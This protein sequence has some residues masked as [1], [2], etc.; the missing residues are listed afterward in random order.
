MYFPFLSIVEWKQFQK[1][2]L[3]LS[4]K[5]NLE[6]L[7][8]E[9]LTNNDV[10]PQISHN[11]RSVTEAESNSPEEDKQTKTNDKIEG[12]E[13]VNRLTINNI[14]NK[15][16]KEEQV[17][18]KTEDTIKMAY[19]AFTCHDSSAFATAVFDLKSKTSE[20]SGVNLKK[21]ETASSEM[22]R[23]QEN[24]ENSR[25]YIGDVS[26][27]R[28]KAQS[29]HN[30]PNSS[31]HRLG[32]SPEQKLILNE[33]KEDEKKN[34]SKSEA[35]SRK[36]SRDESK[37]E[38]KTGKSIFSIGKQMVHNLIRWSFDDFEMASSNNYLHNL[39]KRLTE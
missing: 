23:L 18:Q 7:R 12:L 20:R 28:Q 25:M 14:K 13:K 11:T 10:H 8:E 36:K 9:N 16:K 22:E 24:I 4:V 3:K 38:A 5:D 34:D 1:H 32:T 39:S 33:L 30:I 29:Q 2:F 19:T 37:N 6:L 17:F 26:P 27:V 15:S 31:S 35:C 21:K